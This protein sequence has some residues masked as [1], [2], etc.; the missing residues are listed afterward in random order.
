MT[1]QDEAGLLNSRM[2]DGTLEPRPTGTDV[3]EIP[4]VSEPQELLHRHRPAPGANSDRGFA[5]R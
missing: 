5:P 3:E 1:G 4:E 2:G